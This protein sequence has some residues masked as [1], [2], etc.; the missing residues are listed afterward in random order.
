[1]ER[2]GGFHSIVIVCILIL[3][4]AG[5]AGAQYGGGSGRPDDPYLIYT[6]EQ[7]N[8]I[9]ADPNDWDKHFQL[10][11]DIDLAQ[12]TG[13]A[14]NL[15]GMPGMVTRIHGGGTAET[16]TAFAGSF[17]GN[18]HTIAN[19]TYRCEELAYIGLFARV[20]DPNAEIRNV[21]LSNP[22]IDAGT[23]TNV[24]A[25][26]GYL[27][28]GTITSCH[29]EGGTLLGADNVGGLI[30]YNDQGAIINC[31]AGSN[32]SGER[33]IGVLV[34]RQ[35]RG[36]VANCRAAGSAAGENSVGGLIGSNAGTVTN[37]YALGTV[38]GD[39]DTGGLLGKTD[40]GT[41]TCCY[42]AGPVA[43]TSASDTGGLIGWNWGSSVLACFWD[44]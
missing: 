38:N 24:G 22:D 12:Y 19:F 34:G 4:L 26:V 25:L 23:G 36:A 2:N 11:A 29:V 13:A 42:A 41:V 14:F 3:A 8:A 28:D 39:R 37:C 44:V 40:G 27:R 16:P 15:I 5:S 1:M 43:G 21:R 30:G 20:D 31:D 7:M 10:R 33:N 35:N 18:G 17:D 32:V 6:P 9:G